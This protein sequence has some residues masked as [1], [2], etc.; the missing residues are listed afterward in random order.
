MQLKLALVIFKIEFIKHD[1][2]EVAIKIVFDK[3]AMA[4]VHK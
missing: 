4:L 1:L 2:P 3:T